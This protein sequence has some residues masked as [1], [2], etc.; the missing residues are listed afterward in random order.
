[1][2]KPYFMNIMQS[3]IRENYNYERVMLSFQLYQTTGKNK[4][5]DPLR[6]TQANEVNN[7]LP[8]RP[9]LVTRRPESWACR[10]A[11]IRQALVCE[12]P[13][14][15][16]H[17]YPFVLSYGAWY[18]ASHFI[19]KDDYYYTILYVVCCV[20]MRSPYMNSMLKCI[21]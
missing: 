3:C 13:F 5:P 14:H 1:M 9:E 12:V 15:A 11:T 6:T 21:C 7:T 8:I 2:K 10:F 16:L 4:Q 20:Y 19:S 18:A 17:S